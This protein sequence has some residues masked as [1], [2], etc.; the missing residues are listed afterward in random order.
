QNTSQA[1]QPDLFHPSGLAPDLRIGAFLWVQRSRARVGGSK[2]ARSDGC[3][4]RSAIARSSPG[5]PRVTAVS[6]PHALLS[7]RAGFPAAR[8]MCVQCATR[9]DSRLIAAP[10]ELRTG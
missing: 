7:A 2:V 5:V 9:R 3:A 10:N 4:P 1:C 8:A 6:F